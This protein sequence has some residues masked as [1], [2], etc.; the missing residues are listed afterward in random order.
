MT[1]TELRDPVADRLDH[2]RVL[3]NDILALTQQVVDGERTA[4]PSDDLRA[5]NTLA[6]RHLL[7][8]DELVKRRG[9]GGGTSETGHDRVP[10]G[11]RSSLVEEL[12]ETVAAVLCAYGALYAVG[13]LL[14]ETEV[15]DDLAYPHGEEWRDALGAMADVLVTDVHARLLAVGYTCR[16]ICPACGMG[17]CLCSRNSIET[18][19]ELWGLPEPQPRAGIELR[20]P[21]RPDSALARIGMSPGD[22]IVLVDGEVVR[23]NGD[24]Q[25]A[26]RKHDVGEPI[27]IQIERSGG[28]EEVR[29]ARVSDLP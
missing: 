7:A 18:L 20:I 16:C 3:E 29:A 8:I 27:A 15:A 11:R 14:Y 12:V 6:A 22:R 10:R 28:L 19:G 4:A 1:E 5:A 13:R 17:A 2:A 9:G 25:A 21:P 23:T 24:L 26:L